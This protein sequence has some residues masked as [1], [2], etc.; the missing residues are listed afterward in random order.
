MVLN[1]LHVLERRAGTIGQGHPVAV[2]DVGV[3][4]EGEDLAAAPRAE[5]DGSRGDGPNLPGGQLD[6]HDPLTPSST[7]SFV[8]KNSSYRSIASY[9]R[10]VWNSVWSK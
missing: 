6:G 1:E 2:L 4:G 10:V 5:D 8:T 7:R 9:F 3:G